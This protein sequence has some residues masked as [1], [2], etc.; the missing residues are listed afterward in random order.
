VPTALERGF[1]VTLTAWQG[2]QAPKGLP[3]PV[4][5]K[6]VQAFEK[7]MK[8]PEI[9][10]TFAKLDSSV[11]YLNPKDMEKQSQQEYRSYVGV[12]E[13]MRKK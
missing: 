4:R 11:A 6:L 10:N 9:I 1:D 8:D 3:R 7:A 13:K 12:W 5:D 2:L